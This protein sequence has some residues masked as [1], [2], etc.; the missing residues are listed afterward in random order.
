M[1]VG[2]FANKNLFVAFLMFCLAS[3]ASSQTVDLT[4][5]MTGPASV[6]NGDFSDI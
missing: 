6:Q 3:A 1:N 5:T 4:I 2:L